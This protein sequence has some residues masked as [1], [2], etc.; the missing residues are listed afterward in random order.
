MEEDIVQNF[1]N[2]CLIGEEGSYSIF[3]FITREIVI[4]EDDNEF[5]EVILFLKQSEVHVYLNLK[6]LDNVID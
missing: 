6:E 2:Y 5:T 4:I 3:N 1:E